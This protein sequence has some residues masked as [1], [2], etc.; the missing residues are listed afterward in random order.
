MIAQSTEP[1]ISHTPTLGWVI[2]NQPLFPHRCNATTAFYLCFKLWAPEHSD[3]WRVGFWW[4]CSLKKKFKS[5]ILIQGREKH[6]LVAPGQELQGQMKSVD[7]CGLILRS[8]ESCLGS[9]PCSQACSGCPSDLRHANFP[10]KESLQ[11]VLKQ[12]ALIARC[13]GL[14]VNRWQNVGAEHAA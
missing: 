3:T 7:L 5:P 9:C 10:M 2:K 1:Y 11:Q 4:L 8:S 6:L 14:L 12:R 13:I